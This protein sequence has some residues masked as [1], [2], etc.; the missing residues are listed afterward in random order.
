MADPVPVEY[1][2]LYAELEPQLAEFAACVSGGWDGRKSDVLFSAELLSA[3]GNRGLAMLEPDAQE[4]IYL[5]LDRLQ[6]LGVGA[7]S[8]ALNFPLLYE[9]F[10][11]F[12]GTPDNYQRFLDFYVDLSANIQSR[13]MKL[14]VDNN[15]VFTGEVSAG[16]GLDVASYYPTLDFDSLVAGRSKQA[17]TILNRVKPYSINLGAEPDTQANILEMQELSTPTG[18]GIFVARV[19]TIIRSNL[20]TSIPICAG[21]GT[22][23]GEGKEFIDALILAGIDNIDLHIYPINYQ[24]LLPNLENLADHTIEQGKRVSMS[25]CWLQKR[26]DNEFGPEFPVAGRE[27][28]AR[29]PFSFWKPLDQSFLDSLVK[30]A[31]WKNLRFLAPFWSRYFHAY[32]DYSECEHLTPDEVTKKASQASAMAMKNGSFSGTGKLYRDLIAG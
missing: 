12:C 21:V 10:W 2:A 3:N 23:C 6:A 22:W 20:D 17:C 5:E 19:L 16:S 31:H 24:C 4:W 13:R 27:I 28:P 11:E 29:D 26:R 15:V 30:F 7:V 14:L 25:E 18:Y 32:L 9:P 8:I 1:E